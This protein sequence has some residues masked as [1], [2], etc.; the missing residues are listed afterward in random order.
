MNIL[1][2]L[3]T[4]FQLYALDIA[5]EFMLLSISEFLNINPWYCIQMILGFVVSSLLLV[6][7]ICGVV[8]EGPSWRNRLQISMKMN[9]ADCKDVNSTCT[10]FLSGNKKG[11]ISYVN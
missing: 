6:T 9:D 2:Y 5:Y 10:C 11:K 7:S 8:L 3:C 1:I 4:L